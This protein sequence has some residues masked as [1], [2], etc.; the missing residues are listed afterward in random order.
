MKV[1]SPCSKDWEKMHG[2]DR[3]RFCDHCAKDVRNLSAV[4]RKEA[5]RLVRASGG[6]L[7]VR[8]VKDP[9]TGRPL[10]ADHLISIT[11]RSPGIAAG[12]MSASLALSTAAFAQNGS[13]PPTQETTT[14]TQPS[15]ADTENSTPETSITQRSLEVLPQG[16]QFQTMGAVAFTTEFR[17]EN[18]LTIAVQNDDI[19]EVRELIAKGANVNGKEKSKITPLFI[20]VENGSYEIAK[21]LLEFGAKVNARDGEKQTPLMRLD[22]DATI[23][24]VELLLTYGANVDLEDKAGNTALILSSETAGSDVIKRLIDARSDVNAANKAGQTALMNAADG[25]MLENVRLLLLGGAKVNLRN[26]EGDSAWDLTGNDEIEDLLVSFGA[27]VPDPEPQ[28]DQSE[29]P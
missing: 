19:D 25:E 10:F 29:T 15:G 16:I 1:A 12:V 7:C 11:R 23:E 18:Q 14:V 26:K 24:L 13:L 21:V 9:R 6:G 22:D 17:Y 4:T 5:V 3:V 27:E 2:N 28:A 20:A 8:Y